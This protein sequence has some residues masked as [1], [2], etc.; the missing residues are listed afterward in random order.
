MIA[1]NGQPSGIRLKKVHVMLFVSK[2]LKKKP[3]HLIS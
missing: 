1:G 2:R 3:G